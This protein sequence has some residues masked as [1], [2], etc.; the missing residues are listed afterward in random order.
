M[1]PVRRL[2]QSL[3]DARERIAHHRVD[4]AVQLVA[5][6]VGGDVDRPAEGVVRERAGELVV[7]RVELRRAAALR[8][9][10]ERR[11]G[12]QQHR[13]EQSYKSEDRDGGVAAVFHRQDESL[14]EMTRPRDDRFR[15]IKT[16]R[17]A[18]SI[19]S[20]EVG[21]QAGYG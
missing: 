3:V 5:V 8:R 21:R 12:A 7:L 4:I 11:D 19:W 20:S 17:E 13:G 1:A 9:I 10:R 6:L 18:G 15:K 16:P 2:P 14:N